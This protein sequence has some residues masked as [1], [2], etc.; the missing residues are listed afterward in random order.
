MSG[1]VVAKRPGGDYRKAA[2]QLWQQRLFLR[3]P[4]L[5]TGAQLAAGKGPTKGLHPNILL[6]ASLAHLLSSKTPAERSPFEP[7]LE[8]G[9]T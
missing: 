3:Q 4:A 9:G 8:E 2:N 1:P 6:R 7:F 5:G